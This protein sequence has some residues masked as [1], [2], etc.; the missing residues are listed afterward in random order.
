MTFIAKDAGWYDD[1]KNLVFV[2]NSDQINSVTV[3]GG[4]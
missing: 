2:G 3:D 1:G 4:R